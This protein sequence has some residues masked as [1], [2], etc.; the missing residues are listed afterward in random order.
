MSGVGFS[1]LLILALI[2]LIVLGPEKLP[3]VASQIGNWVGQARRMT[4]VMR[5]QLEDELDFDED[6]KPKSKP[7]GGTPRDDDTYSPAHIAESNALS[8]V[9]DELATAPADKPEINGDE[10]DGVEKAGV[11]KDSAAENCDEDDAKDQVSAGD[12][13]K[14]PDSEPEEKK[15]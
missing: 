2:G 12:S 5:R 3:R 8:D 1:E 14:S 10:D 7:G 11:E 6:L 15:P 4:R 9:A 13:P